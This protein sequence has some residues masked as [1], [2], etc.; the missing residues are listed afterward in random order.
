MNSDSDGP[1][2]RFP[3][4]FPDRASAIG[5]SNSVAE[6]LLLAQSTVALEVRVSRDSAWADLVTELR[7]RERDSRGKS[8]HNQV[9]CCKNYCV[10]YS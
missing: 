4:L 5:A 1:R 7:R 10:E 8:P 6:Y 2:E 3:L 9:I